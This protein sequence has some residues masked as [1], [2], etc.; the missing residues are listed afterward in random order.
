MFLSSLSKTTFFSLHIATFQSSQSGV[1]LIT[2]IRSVGLGRRG[3]SPRLFSESFSFH[4]L[5]PGYLFLIHNKGNYFTAYWRGSLFS[6]FV[7]L[8]FGVYICVPCIEDPSCPGTREPP[9]LMRTRSYSEWHGR[10][11]SPV[12]WKVYMISYVQHLLKY[13]LK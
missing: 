6:I 11:T 2:F 3:S 13:A 9:W 4:F 8:V 1:H 10:L 12:T 7:C 5:L